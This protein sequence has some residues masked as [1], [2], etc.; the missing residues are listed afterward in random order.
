MQNVRKYIVDLCEKGIFPY[1]GN[2]FKTK[3]EEEQEEKQKETKD[4]VIALNKWIINEEEIINKESFTKHFKIQ[5]PTEMFKSIYQ[6][7]DKEKN[8]KLVDVIISGLKDLF[9]EEKEIEDPELIVEIVEEIL[10]FNKQKRE[11]KGIKILTTNQMLGRLPISLA[12]LEAGNNSNKLKNEIRQLLYSLYC[13]KNMTKQ[14]YNN[15]I[16]R[17]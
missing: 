13:S 10:K 17:I 9:K 11:G 12:Q 14:V 8:N 2:V 6:T 5:S 1:K 3:Q 16:K 7:N 4:D 15:L